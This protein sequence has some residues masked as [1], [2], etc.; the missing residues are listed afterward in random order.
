MTRDALQRMLAHS[1]PTVTQL[2]LSKVLVV[3]GRSLATVV[4]VHICKHQQAAFTLCPVART[5][6]QQ[7]SDA[8]TT[9]V[10]TTVV[11]ITAVE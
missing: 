1:P 6:P 3:L 8:R 5:V 11:M 10:E 9:L 7:C 2:P 4:A